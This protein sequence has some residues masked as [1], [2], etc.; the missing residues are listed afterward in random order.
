MQK[1]EYAELEI[2]IGGP[3]SGT[4]CEAIIYQ[5]NQ[6]HKKIEG[7][8]GKLIAQMGEDGWELIVASAR[9]ETGL[10]G[11]HKINYMFK[12]LKNS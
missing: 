5:P 12:R 10:G 11:K 7:K 4:K 9:T 3:L 6:D 1:W 8:F 2:T